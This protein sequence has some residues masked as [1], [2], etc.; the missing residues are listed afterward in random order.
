VKNGELVVPP[1]EYFVMGD[2]RDHS[3]DSRY[4]G[5]VPRENVVGRPI[6]IYWS[7]DAPPANSVDGKLSRLGF[8]LRHLPGLIRWHRM[9]R[10]VY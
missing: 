4:W 7:I 5:F 6:V 10:I 9:L 3:L 8:V 1:N 2:N